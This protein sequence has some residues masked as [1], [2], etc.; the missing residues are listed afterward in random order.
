MI[1]PLWPENTKE[2]SSEGQSTKYLTNTLQKLSRPSKKTKKVV[3]NCHKQEEPK[4]T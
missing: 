3:T 2:I 1:L 4:E